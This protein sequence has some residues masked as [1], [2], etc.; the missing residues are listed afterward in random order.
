VLCRKAQRGSPL[1]Y[2]CHTPSYHGSA[3]VA[4][5]ATYDHRWCQDQCPLKLRVAPLSSP[6]HGAESP[7]YL[8]R[9]RHSDTNLSLHFKLSSSSA[10]TPQAAAP[11]FPSAICPVPSLEFAEL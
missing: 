10:A 1:L 7:H 4:P 6:I 2:V 11:P 9:Q 3:V 8:S 5:L